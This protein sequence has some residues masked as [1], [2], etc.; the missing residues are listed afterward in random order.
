MLGMDRRYFD[1]RLRR[2]QVWGEQQIMDGSQPPCGNSFRVW[3]IDQRES[4]VSSLRQPNLLQ[5]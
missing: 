4:G 2:V 1:D 5:S 3:F